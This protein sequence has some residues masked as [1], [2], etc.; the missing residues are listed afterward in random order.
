VNSD[1]A[2]RD[3]LFSTREHWQTLHGVWRDAKYE[4][5]GARLEAAAKGD[6]RYLA[7]V[8]EYKAH[9]LEL[10][11]RLNVCLAA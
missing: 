5:L 7:G 2:V 3:E 11:E 6:E 9:L 1:R 8:D 10:M 4:E